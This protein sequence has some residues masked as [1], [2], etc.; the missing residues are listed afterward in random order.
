MNSACASSP[1][2]VVNSHGCRALRVASKN[3]NARSRREA[4]SAKMSCSGCRP[5]AGQE[6]G[7]VA[8]TACT[9]VQRGQK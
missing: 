4:I 8:A 6:A 7:A 5:H 1:G 9:A 2:A 3:P